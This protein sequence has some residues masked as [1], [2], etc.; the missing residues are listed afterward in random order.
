VCLQAFLVVGFH[1]RHEFTFVE[2]RV[3]SIFLHGFLDFHRKW[4]EVLRGE[5]EDVLDS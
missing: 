1:A 5:W 4:T 2:L 3:G